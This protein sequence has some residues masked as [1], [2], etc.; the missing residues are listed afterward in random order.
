MA[1]VMVNLSTTATDQ[2]RC[3]RQI[4]EDYQDDDGDGGDGDD[5][6]DGDDD[7][8]DDDGNDGHGD[9]ELVLN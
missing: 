9:G 3:Q 5:D 4:V 2:K 1:K 7:G 8:N 6:N